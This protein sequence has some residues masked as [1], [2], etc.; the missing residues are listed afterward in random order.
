MNNKWIHVKEALPDEELKCFVIFFEEI[1]IGVL[2]EDSHW[3]VYGYASHEN[4]RVDLKMIK[5]WR[6]IELSL[7]DEYI[8]SSIDADILNASASIDI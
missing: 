5:W 2:V 8:D 6:P 4:K 7:P 1:C 3:N